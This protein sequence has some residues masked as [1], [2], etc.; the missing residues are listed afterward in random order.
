MEYIDNSKPKLF[1]LGYT[2]LALVVR[3]LLDTE[4]TEKPDKI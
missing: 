3:K 1:I 4:I 2:I